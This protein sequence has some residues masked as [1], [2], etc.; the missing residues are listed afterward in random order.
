M[1]VAAQQANSNQVQLPPVNVTGLT[2]SVPDVTPDY[3][4]N[5]VN[6]GPLGKKP[7]IDTPFS[8]NTVSEDLA[9]NQQL[10]SLQEAFRLIPSVQGVNI[11]PQ[12]R[13]LQSS[14]VQNTLIDGLNIAATTDYPLEEF[15]R[16][17]VLNGL[18]GAFFGPAQP[19]GTFNYIMKRPTSTPLERVT[20][21]YLSQGQWF[22][23]ADF[24]GF[25]D[26]DQRFGYRL[27]LLNQD[28]ESFVENGQL[29]RQLAS[30]GGDIHFTPDTVLETNAS[31]YH[32]RTKGL[33]GTF[34]VATGVT[35]PTAL[36]AA[37]VGYGQPW[38]GD[39][40]V[41]SILSGRIKHDFN[42][43]WNMT[44]GILR[45]TSDRSS[46]V[47]TNTITNNAGAYTT[48]T[49]TT[50]YSLDNI[51]SN[52]VGLNGRLFT[53]PLKHDLF[54]ANN[55]FFW[56][57]YTPYQTGSITV[58]K[59]NLGDPLIFNEPSLPDFKNRF[60]AMT[61]TQQSIT[62]GDTIALNQQWSVMGALSDSWIDVHNYSSTS[63]ITSQFSAN[64]WSPLGS[65]I[66]KPRENMSTYFTYAD[67][68][69]QGDSAPAGTKNVGQTLAPYRS[70]QYELG[71]KV[72]LGR[73]NLNAAL[74][75][76]ERPYAYTGTNNVFAVQGLQRNRGV[77][78]MATGAINDGF[79]LF[80]GATYID[81][82][83]YD[84]GSVTTEGKRILGLSQFVM[85]T[86][87]EYHVPVVKGLTL[88]TNVNF[89][90]NR[91]GDNANTTLVSGYAL[92]DLGLRYVQQVQNKQV[93]FRLN[94]FNVTNQQYW[95]NI[96]PSSQNGYNATGS[97]TGTLG[98]PRT[99]RASLQV[100]L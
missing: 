99:I 37:R 49:T 52:Q 4:V 27:N 56:D 19:G 5:N 70:S 91:P 79:T 90:T 33:P 14:V 24:G 36:N 87:L 16:I 94:V 92:L 34:A 72:D 97:G 7:L 95:A 39:D 45:N 93:T 25:A 30:F 8:V 68:L 1:Q 58:G 65:L 57:R 47:P 44:A 50:T 73:I 10:Q 29:R 78:L 6:I 22:G 51:V 43:D 11:R 13:G 53:G 96:A 64:G 28:G 31:I 74:Y 12:T 100:D 86:L 46:T 60:L 88:S 75:Q 98:A 54:F 63:A 48:T 69:Q 66:F 83:L 59:A 23:H 61:T 26:A 55:G 84:T 62:A 21:G 82:R 76:I 2:A 67:S 38:G 18:A 81:P 71:Y 20:G 77:E 41:T 89:A 9:E 85:N 40:N 35:F 15:Q 80:G 3:K 32:Y 17:D 42:N